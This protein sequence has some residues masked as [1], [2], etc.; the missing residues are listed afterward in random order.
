MPTVA[1][2]ANTIAVAIPYLSAIT[3][4]VTNLS[5][6]PPGVT[7]KIQTAMDSVQQGVAA[8]AASET[9]VQS[10][11]IVDRI[12]ADA[13]AV[14]TV[15]AALPLPFPVNI[16]LMVASSLLP[17]VLSAVNLLMANHATVPA[18]PP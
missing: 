3:A 5:H 15:A 12:A 4:A 11:P 6:T 14:L 9:A 16:I 10:K 7:T 1:T 18:A 8:L 13:Q 17:T 2:A